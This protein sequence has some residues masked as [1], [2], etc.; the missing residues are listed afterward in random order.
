LANS[1][2]NLGGY[3]NEVGRYSDAL[4]VLQA[5]HSS[6][7]RL[8]T[9]HAR[10]EHLRLH[11]DILTNLAT[12]YG[13]LDRREEALNA[14]VASVGVYRRLVEGNPTAYTHRLA[15]SLSNRGRH[16]GQRGH[17]DQAVPAR[18]NA[19]TKLSP[20]RRPKLADQSGVAYHGLPRSVLVDPEA[21]ECEG[22]AAAGPAIVPDTLIVDHGKIFVSH[23]LN[24]VCE[25][26]GVSIQPARV[27]IARD[28]GPVERFFRTLRE[29]LLH[30]AVL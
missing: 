17:D 3:R 20:A 26:L 13:G 7:V 24:S 16:Y 25:R 11:A 12:C 8:A 30:M 28:K 9:E 6:A 22:P 15:K 1:L 4:P 21:W 23:H 5:S 29:G 10:P 27:G 19:T 14:A 2:N 18:P